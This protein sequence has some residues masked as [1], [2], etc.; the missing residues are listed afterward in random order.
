MHLKDIFSPE[1]YLVNRKVG[2]ND[3][4]LTKIG[5]H[6]AKIAIKKGAIRLTL[7]TKSALSKFDGKWIRLK[8]TSSDPVYICM[9]EGP[10]FTSIYGNLLGDGYLKAGYVVQIR[11]GEEYHLNLA[12]RLECIVR[13][14]KV[15]MYHNGTSFKI[16]P[17][18]LRIYKKI[19][20]SPSVLLRCGRPQKI[21]TLI[22]YINDDGYIADGYIE[23]Y[24]GNKNRLA[25]FRRLCKLLGY[26]ISR[27]EQ[28]KNK[29][30][31]F[32]IKSKGLDAFIKDY[33]KLIEK[34][35]LLRLLKRKERKIL[36]RIKRTQKKSRQVSWWENHT[37][38]V[39]I[40]RNEGPK[41]CRELAERLLVSE[42]MV[43]RIVKDLRKRKCIRIEKKKRGINV[44]SFVKQFDVQKK[45]DMYMDSVVKLL[46]D[47]RER[48]TSEV[49]REIGKKL[50]ISKNY[51]S[52]VLCC[53]SKKGLIASKRLK[54]K[55]PKRNVWTIN[56][57]R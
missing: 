26:D 50:G 25:T 8:T 12:K 19:Y 20:P 17:P 47:G 40:L 46:S 35:P 10:I 16:P 45:Y 37:K 52:A 3:I 13:D 42:R 48:G 15:K 41:T 38:V 31:I 33:F 23:L 53:A 44:C 28:K 6:G 4:N 22:A 49:H 34:Y 21:A 1:L 2:L 7:L 43:N 55:G 5:L 51:T 18:L 54:I 9:D 27:I 14:Y 36:L 39:R 24:D 29:T 56:I 11:D 57:S 30:F 32:R